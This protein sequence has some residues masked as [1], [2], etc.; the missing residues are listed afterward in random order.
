MPTNILPPNEAAPCVLFLFAHNDDELFVLPK[1][2]Q[3]VAQG[4]DVWCIY[5][6]DGAAYGACPEE[7]L[8]ESVKVL[9]SCGVQSAHIIPLGAATA[10]RDGRAHLSIG[11]LYSSID[12]VTHQLRLARIYTLAWEGGHHDHDTTH[13]IA[14]KLSLQRGDIPLFEFSAY[15]GHRMPAPLFD[16]MNFLPSTI[17]TTTCL[18]QLSEEKRT[19]SLR[20][21]IGW[22]R[23]FLSYP[24]QRKTLLALAPI[25]F[26]R[27]VVQRTERVRRVEDYSYLEPPHEGRLLYER[28]F[29]VTFEQFVQATHSF[30]ATMG[31]DRLN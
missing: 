15:H 5:T 2:K 12:E 30:I 7:R 6:T 25:C 10:C 8:N 24:T 29:G 19:L 22:F 4:A 16:C 28:L 31:T 1:I 13:L 18:G 3:E 20:E 26:I 9:S 11:T 21:S 23:R 27:I 14:R 17:L